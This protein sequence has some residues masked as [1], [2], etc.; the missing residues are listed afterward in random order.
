MSA[1]PAFSH[2][3]AHVF[4]NSPMR[5]PPRWKMYSALARRLAEIVFHV[6]HQECDYF[7]VV[8][9]GVVRG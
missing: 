5:C 7:T 6:W 2:A 1:R 3:V 9:H 8:R 4:L